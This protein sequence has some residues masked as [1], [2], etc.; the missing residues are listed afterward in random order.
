MKI[1]EDAADEDMLSVEVLKR[2]GSVEQLD[3]MTTQHQQ[4]I[5]DGRLTVTIIVV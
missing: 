1:V 3:E 2:A 5:S 4:T